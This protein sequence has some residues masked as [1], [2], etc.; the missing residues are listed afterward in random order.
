MILNFIWWPIGLD[1]T[2]KFQ[3]KAG[4]ASN[5]EIFIRENGLAE[6]SVFPGQRKRFVMLNDLIN[7]Y[8][9]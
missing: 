8:F 7:L 9:A 3:R 4:P 6:F 1:F 2:T 5:L